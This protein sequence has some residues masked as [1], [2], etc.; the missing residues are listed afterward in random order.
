MS[1]KHRTPTRVDHEKFCTTE[2]WVRRKNATGKR[3]TDHVRYELPLPDGSILYTRISHPVNR[4]HEYGKS[5]W[6]HILRDQL[7]VSADEFWACVEDGTLP[8]RGA[9]PEA[10]GEAIPAGVV[11]TLISE[12]HLPEAQVRKMTKP[13]AVQRLADYYTKGE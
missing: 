3:G 8:D 11:Q 12:V 4:R 7:M 2:G 10:T 13:E 5:R 1:G 6:T 9:P